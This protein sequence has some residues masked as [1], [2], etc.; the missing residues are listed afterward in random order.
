M[1]ELQHI[2]IGASKGQHPTAKSDNEKLNQNKEHLKL[3]TEDFS[4]TEK[5]ILK[6]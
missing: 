1:V 5:N 6:V 3:E 4:L 2:F